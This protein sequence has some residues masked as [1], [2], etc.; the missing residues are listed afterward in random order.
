[1]TRPSS[2]RCHDV[3]FHVPRVA[4]VSDMTPTID[5]STWVTKQQAADQL[6]VSTKAIERF[7]AAGKLEQRFRRQA[8]SP[9]VAVYFPDD[10]ADLAATRRAAGSAGFLV[11]GRAEIPANGNG[12]GSSLEPRALSLQPSVV[13]SSGQDLLTAIVTAALQIVSETSQ[14]PALFL[15]LAQAAA[16]SG[17]TQAYLRRKCVDGTLPAI[18][19]PGWRIRRKDLEAL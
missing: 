16:Y 4:D 1:M 14:T 19:D 9:D 11:P 10:V 5:L 7:T 3:P 6:G 17:L 12:H 2:R 15:T 13:P 8:G 18:R